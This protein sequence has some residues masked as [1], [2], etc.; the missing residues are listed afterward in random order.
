MK[1]DLPHILVVDDDE[2]IR[3]L[4]TRYLTAQNMV[5]IAAEDAVQARAFLKDLIFDL[6]VLDIMMPGESGLN[7]TRYI[8]DSSDLPVILL[9]ARAEVDERIE[10]LSAG[11]DDYLPKPFEPKELVLRIT[12]I[13]RRTKFGS[14]TSQLSN[15]HS[16][17]DMPVIGPWAFDAR[18]KKLQST[19]NDET[20]ILTDGEV[21]LLNAL[22]RRPNTPIRRDILAQQVGMAGQDRAIDVQITRLRKKIEDDPKTPK[23]VQTI[24]G[25]GYLIRQ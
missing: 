2:R 16:T 7:L 11:A 22:L 14:V 23:Y 19:A 25:Q 13:L 12:A 10:G 3:S 4:L 21:A 15:E 17:A 5:V 20:V 18:L 8:K 9:T 24:R 1:E 6:A